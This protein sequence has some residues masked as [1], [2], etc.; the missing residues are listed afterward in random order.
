LDEKLKKW[1]KSPAASIFHDLEEVAETIT[2]SV[3]S[4]AYKTFVADG[5]VNQTVKWYQSKCLTLSKN[6]PAHRTLMLKL[7][8]QLG[9]A[10]KSSGMERAGAWEKVQAL[11]DQLSREMGP[12][13]GPV[14]KWILRFKQRLAKAGITQIPVTGSL[15]NRIFVLVEELEIQGIKPSSLRVRAMGGYRFSVIP[16][17]LAKEVLGAKPDP[18][19]RYLWLRLN[20]SKE[21]D[22]FFEQI[23]KQLSLER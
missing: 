3:N 17:D 7:Y 12:P 14:A 21:E 15:G 10:G 11:T 18:P 5:S 16:R 9:R 19:S 4:G 20:P 8:D 22:V 2:L 1:F 13:P 23:R 6:S